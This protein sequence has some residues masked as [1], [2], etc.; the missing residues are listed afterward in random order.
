MGGLEVMGN[1]KVP[2]P[3][4]HDQVKPPPPPAP[5]PKRPFLDVVG[6]TGAKVT[7]EVWR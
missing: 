4:P 2:N 7:I 3:P 6:V 1:R 5:P